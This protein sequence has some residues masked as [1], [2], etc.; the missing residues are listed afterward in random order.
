MKMLVKRLCLFL[1][2]VCV[3]LGF[4]FA[5][6]PSAAVA[7]PTRIVIS[8]L[9]WDSVMFHNEL[10]KF[11]I[12]NAFDGY[13]VEFAIGSTALNWQ[14]MIQ[15][16]IDV[17]LETWADNLSFFPDDV[18]RGDIIPLGVLVPDS[19]QGF[20]VPRYVIEGDPERG[21]EPMAPTLRHVRDL[22]RY[23]RVFPD[24]DYPARARIYGGIPGWE[25]TEI[26]HRKVL[27]YG[28]YDAGFNYFRV[29]SEP[30]LFTSLDAAYNLGEPWVG[31]M[32]EPSS[33][34]GRLDLVMLEDEPFDPVLYEQGATEIPRQ[35]LLNVSGAHFPGKAPGLLDFFRNFKTG[36]ALVSEV[37]AYM[38]ETGESHINAA[39]WFMKTNDNL[40]DE[41]LNPEQAERM[42]SALANL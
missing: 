3:T 10:A 6:L 1:C 37:L 20:Y 27:H 36:S 42:R 25:I 17:N 41:W 40:L 7:A 29:G 39:I 38:E 33:I 31:Y 9:Q 15:G 14:A 2:A 28:L 32:W 34:Y 18:A 16:D 26:M 12:E 19:A 30:I 11:V 13:V 21:I 22:A 4:F 35:A 5:V 8:N 23:A 24:P